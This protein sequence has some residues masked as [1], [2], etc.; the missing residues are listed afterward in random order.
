M[1]GRRSGV[2]RRTRT[3]GNA[4]SWPDRG[5]IRTLLSVTM[6]TVPAYKD[7]RPLTIVVRVR[8]RCIE[9]GTPHNVRQLVF[10]ERRPRH[11]HDRILWLP[12][13]MLRQQDGRCVP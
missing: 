9:C 3:G 8:R 13:L 12:Y 4:M 5:S 1:G 10:P 2:Q 7:V 6:T 11:P